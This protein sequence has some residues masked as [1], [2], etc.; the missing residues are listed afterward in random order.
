M[1]KTLDIF[2]KFATDETAEVNGAIVEFGGTKFTIARA[3]N[4]KYT[5]LLSQLVDKHRA[6]LD[7]KDE[8]ADALSDRILIEVLAT[9]ILLGWDKLNYQ[10]KPMEY[11]IENASKLLAHKDF[12]RE[13]SRMSEDLDNFRAKFEAEQEKN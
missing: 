5:K 11:S 9:T 12:R 4:P 13:V 2:E 6:A 1:T 10:K 3:G 8:S 7:L